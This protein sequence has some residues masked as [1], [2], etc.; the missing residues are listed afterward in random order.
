MTKILKLDEL[1]SGLVYLD[2]LS[3]RIVI[4][5]GLLRH[6]ILFAMIVRIIQLE[7]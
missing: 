7:S 5:I 1:R 4:E 2:V 3:K 6:V